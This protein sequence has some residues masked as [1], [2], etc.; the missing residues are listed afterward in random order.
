MA[1]ATTPDT[2]RARPSTVSIAVSL[3]YVVVVLELVNAVLYLM[4][5][6]AYKTAY[7]KTYAGTSLAGQEGQ[8]AAINV[9]APAVLGVILAIVFFVLAM[10]DG[11]G[12]RVARI[13]TWVF[14][15]LA[16]CCT[17]VGLAFVAASKSLYESARNQNSDL[18]PYDTMMN[19]VNAA[20]PSWF[21]AVTGVIGILVLVAIIVAAILLALPASNAF[22]RK[23]AEP[24]WTPPLPPYPPTTPP[25]DTPSP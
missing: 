7:E 15:G 14:S 2:P 20:L 1:S 21:G 5:Y 16:V 12:N 17:G 4:N 23:R 11:R 13:I 25:S 9:A 6:G 18:P 8:Q 10:L 22:F 3:L 24:E 19:N